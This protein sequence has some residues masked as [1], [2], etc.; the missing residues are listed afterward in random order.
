[1]AD[2]NYSIAFWESVAAQFRDNPM[3]AFDAYNEPHGINWEC[4]RNGCTID[5]WQTAGMQ[6]IV[7]AIRSTGA[8]QP[9]ILS[10]LDWA[11][12]VRGWLDHVPSDPA[13]NLVAGFHVYNRVHVDGQTYDKRCRDEN[14]WTNELLPIVQAGYPVI[15][16]EVGQDVG[17]NTCGADFVDR[18]YTWADQHNISYIAWSYNPHGCGAPSLITSWDGSLSTAGY[19]LAAHLN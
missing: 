8:T 17:L 12:D 14:C 7:N 5:G 19:A 6:Q 15:A 1:M 2:A 18:F 13:D 11:G 16:T 10:G 9:I 3:V 4:W